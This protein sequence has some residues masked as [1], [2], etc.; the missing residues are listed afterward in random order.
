MIKNP[1]IKQMGS[2]RDLQDYADKAEDIELKMLIELVN[3]Y[4]TELPKLMNLLTRKACHQRRKASGRGNN[5]HCSQGKRH[6]I[7]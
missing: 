6:G 5:F 1:L 2:Y 7:R 4:K 3:E